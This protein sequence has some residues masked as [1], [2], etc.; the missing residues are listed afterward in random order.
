MVN[1][2]KPFGLIFLTTEFIFLSKVLLRA[3]GD[4][5][6]DRRNGSGTY[7]AYQCR[8]DGDREGENRPSLFEDYFSPGPRRSLLLAETT[9][10]LIG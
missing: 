10:K 5:P 9:S 1:F 7:S 4:G 8:F 6:L 2:S 3:N